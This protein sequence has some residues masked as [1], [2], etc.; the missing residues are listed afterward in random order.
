LIKEKKNFDCY[1]NNS[2][3]KATTLQ[4]EA[5]FFLLLFTLCKVEAFLLDGGLMFQYLSHFYFV[6]IASLPRVPM[7]ALANVKMVDQKSN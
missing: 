1:N 2:T 6:Q 5:T 4:K 7:F 3:L